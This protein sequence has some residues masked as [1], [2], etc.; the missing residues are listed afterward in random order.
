MS[1]FKVDM[2]T[3]IHK[4]NQIFPKCITAENYIQQ[5]QK[6]QTPVVQEQPITSEKL[7][8]LSASS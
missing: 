2:S 5:E 1:T 7:S 3:L 4:L 6:I 8:D